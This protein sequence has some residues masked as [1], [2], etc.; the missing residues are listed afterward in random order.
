MKFIAAAAL[1]VAGLAAAQNPSDYFPSCGVPCLTDAVKAVTTCD[2]NNGKCI[3][4]R[5][6][7]VKVADAATT[8]VIDK[9]GITVAIGEFVNAAGKYC[10]AAAAAPAP[11]S[12]SS[13]AAPPPSSSAQ[14]SA[15]APSTSAPAPSSSAPA[16]SSSAPATKA[17]SSAASA[18]ATDSGK[19]VSSTLTSTVCNSCKATATAPAN[20]TTKATQ[21][22]QVTAGAAVAAPV[23]IAAIFGL[24]A[25]VL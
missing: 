3:C 1:A 14:S 22:P 18:S 21:P 9:C 11:A 25:F 12:S 23:G 17:T 7:Y 19:V 20:G 24:A 6:T 8:C 13:S 10:E 2:V 15:P 16:P 4:E 5:E